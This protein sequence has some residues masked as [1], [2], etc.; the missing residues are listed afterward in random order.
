LPSGIYFYRVRATSLATG[1]EF[2]SE[3]RRMILMK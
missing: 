1:K 3:T 2:T